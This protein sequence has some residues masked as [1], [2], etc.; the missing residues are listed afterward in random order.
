MQINLS[1]P[2]ITENI[3]L[4][5]FNC[6]RVGGNARYFATPKS[7]QELSNL[8]IFIKNSGIKYDIIS[9]GTN[10]IISD[11]NY[12][13][14]IILLNRLNN[15]IIK[16]GNNIKVGASVRLND[17]IS[18]TIESS[19]AGLESLVGVP[20]LI[21]GAAIMNAGAYGVEF[22][23][24]TVSL[25]VIDTQGVFS[26]ISK[27]DVGF[28]YRHTKNL[29]DKIVVAAEIELLKT[30]KLELLKKRSEILKTRAK[31]QPLDKPSCGSVFKRP[32]DGYAGDLIERAGLKGFRYKSVM[33]SDKHSNF[34][35]GCEKDI[36]ANDLYHLIA[37]II[38]EVQ[39]KFSIT[40]EP[41]VKF[42]GFNSY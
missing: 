13:G 2:L 32:K 4:K 9:A 10:T 36:K 23:D 22:K 41:E 30:D 25:D 24:V 1:H 26:N 21:G 34:I 6:Y 18:Y 33:V 14:L 15:F 40:L 16:N 5:K 35:V 31:K 27:H 11:E 37:Y 17:L 20:G 42:I 7:N 8:L 29:E 12:D 19:L 28:T 39:E 3:S 38:N